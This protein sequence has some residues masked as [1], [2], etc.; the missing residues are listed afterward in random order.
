MEISWVPHSWSATKAIDL[1]NGRAL[2]GVIAEHCF[3]RARGSVP[4]WTLRQ[5][6]SKARV[7]LPVEFI[8][9]D[10]ELALESSRFV[11][12]LRSCD[13]APMA[14]WRGLVGKMIRAHE[15]RSCLMTLPLPH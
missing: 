8:W 6:C 3:S 7:V 2:P 10:A 4:S 1:A 14:E 9:F 5:G 12:L 13:Q 11:F 15:R